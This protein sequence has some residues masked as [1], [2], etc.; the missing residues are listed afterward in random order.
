M[1]VC[2]HITVSCLC[3]HGLGEGFMR[4]WVSVQFDCLGMCAGYS[5]CFS[6]AD[7]VGVN[8]IGK[9]VFVREHAFHLVLLL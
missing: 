5:V 6:A 1:H 7:V 9:L 3:S 2:M 8:I 4:K